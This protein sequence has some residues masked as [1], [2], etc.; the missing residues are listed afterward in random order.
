M[1]AAYAKVYEGLDAARPVRH[2]VR[3]DWLFATL[4]GVLMARAAGEWIVRIRERELRRRRG[5]CRSCGYDLRMTPDRC[6]ECGMAP[7]A[8]PGLVQAGSHIP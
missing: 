8:T 4:L 6:P 2:A 7:V 3:L 5:Q 1:E